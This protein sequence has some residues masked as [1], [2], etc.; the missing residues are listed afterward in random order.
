MYIDTVYE[1]QKGSNH[2]YIPTKHSNSTTNVISLEYRFTFMGPAVTSPQQCEVCV[3]CSGLCQGL[4]M[5]WE[6]T[7]CPNVSLSTS[8]WK[9]TQVNFVVEVYLLLEYINILGKVL[10]KT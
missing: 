9:R 10:C 7:L 5:W 6:L 8:P 3:S 2:H 1:S 4:V